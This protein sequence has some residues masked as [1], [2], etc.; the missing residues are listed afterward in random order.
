M[1]QT[2]GRILARGA[3]MLAVAMAASLPMSLPS[4]AE[5]SPRR[6][7]VRKPTAKRVVEARPAVRGGPVLQ[8]VVFARDL[9]GIQIS[10]DALT[11]W[12][13]AAGRYQ[14]GSR[15]EPGA[16]LSFP[17]S[18]RMR[19]GHAAVVSRV[20]DARE[21][22]VDDANWAM[23]GQP[24]GMVRRGAS[25]I[26]VSPANDWTQVRVQN[27]PGS[28]G[29]VYPTYGFI[30]P[31][32]DRGAELIELAATRDAPRAYH[33]SAPPVTPRGAPPAGLAPGA[34]DRGET[35]ARPTARGLIWATPPAES[36][37]QVTRPAAAAAW[38]WSNGEAVAR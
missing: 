18:G 1:R 34:G 27:V 30:Y 25:V 3:I 21:V 38:V 33:T 23:P 37:A 16:V 29:R 14:R 11:W 4:P 12:G 26:D 17:A 32:A 31:R 15:P 10:G 20:I 22:L 35:T 6:T 9:S 28:W 36:A 5:A 13:K 7:D 19:L 2:T 8:C 24:K